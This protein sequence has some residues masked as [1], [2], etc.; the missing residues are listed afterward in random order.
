MNKEEMYF[1]LSS[2]FFIFELDTEVETDLLELFVFEG[3]LGE[4]MEELY[5]HVN[6]WHL[7]GY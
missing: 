6:S 5:G 7:I 4:T 3:A 2:R 1:G